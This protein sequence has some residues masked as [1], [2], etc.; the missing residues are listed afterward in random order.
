MNV[1][2]MQ[3]IATIAECGSIT[4]AAKELYISQ[5]AL[6]SYLKAQEEQL[7]YRLF[8]RQNKTLIPTAYG[9]IYLEYARRILVLEEEFREQVRIWEHQLPSPLRV[10]LNTI[11]S[12]TYYDALEA[13]LMEAFPGVEI[14]P[15]SISSPQAMEL[16]QAGEAHF[17]LR[18]SYLTPPAPLE[19]VYLMDDPDVVAI[20]DGHPLLER[21]FTDEEGHLSVRSKDLRACEVYIR[22][23]MALQTRQVF[24]TER[25]PQK[26][27]VEARNIHRSSLDTGLA[28]TAVRRK[29]AILMDTMVALWQAQEAGFSLARMAPQIESYYILFTYNRDML[30]AGQMQELLRVTKECLREF[31][32]PPDTLS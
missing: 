3:Y 29:K 31:F 27:G 1:K 5:P 26:Y 14:E 13:A 20:P 17:S 30:P 24:Y 18:N 12:A 19:A 10:V 23:N 8:F 6:S 22:S 25:L 32:T 9:K 16:L 4:K 11:N 21:C 2:E 7:G 28:L 15:I